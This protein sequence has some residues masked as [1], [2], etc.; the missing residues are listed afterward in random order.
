[1]LIQPRPV[2]PSTSIQVGT[3]VVRC[4]Y[5]LAW[6]LHSVPYFIE[7]HG[8]R[9]RSLVEDED[10]VAERAKAHSATGET[11]TVFRLQHLRRVFQVAHDYK[12]GAPIH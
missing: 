5:C 8:V 10:V 6:V 4:Y 7:N 11:G 9:P 1:M 12:A 3:A 2:W